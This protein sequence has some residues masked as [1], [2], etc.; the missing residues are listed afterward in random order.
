M[1]SPDPVAGHAFELQSGPGEG[2][3]RATLVYREGERRLEV[4]LERAFASGQD[5]L[6][7]DSG[8]CEWNEP[9]GLA[10]DPEH[11][12]RVLTRMGE[13]STALGL[14]IELV[15][16]VDPLLDLA[17]RGYALKHHADGS[18]TATAPHRAPRGLLGRLFGL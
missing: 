17:A 16:D 1:S 2:W 12:D 11:V 14:R 15:P 3:S 18:V 8:F 13:W 5:W 4:E 7:P 9:P 10:L 6:A